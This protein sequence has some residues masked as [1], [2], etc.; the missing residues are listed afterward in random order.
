MYLTLSLKYLILAIGLKLL[1]CSR[2]KS[3]FL[4][5]SLSLGVLMIVF[6][7]NSYLSRLSV[8]DWSN[9]SKRWVCFE[10]SCEIGCQRCYLHQLLVKTNSHSVVLNQFVDFLYQELQLLGIVE[11]I[12]KFGLWMILTFRCSFI[13][14]D[15]A[16]IRLR[17]NF[18][19][20]S[21][22]RLRRWIRCNLGRLL[23]LQ[24]YVFWLKLITLFSFA[25][26]GTKFPWK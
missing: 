14:T 19:C 17:L 6:H 15:W 16:L 21:T 10:W 25:V 26:V 2:L 8:L 9:W 18:I 23:W 5:V 1:G 4:F 7:L 12:F 24:S 11:K 13:S 3:S 20:S 22:N